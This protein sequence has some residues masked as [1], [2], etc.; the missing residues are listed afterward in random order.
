M[1]NCYNTSLDK[2]LFKN[3]RNIK[4]F[5]RNK[6]RTLKISKFIVFGQDKYGK[7]FFLYYDY[8]SK[9]LKN[10]PL[11]RN[12]KFF[13]YS[14]VTMKNENTMIVCGGIKY[15]LRDITNIAFEY[16]FIT[17]SC[18]RLPPM[19]SIRYTFPILYKDNFIYV[20]GGRTYGD[21]Y[22]SLLGKCERYDYRTGRWVEIASMTIKRCTCSVFVFNNDIWAIGGYTGRFKRSKKIE[23]YIED[24]DVWEVLDFKL[25][26]GFENGNVIPGNRPN[27]ILILG[28]KLNFG[29]SKNVWEYNLKN[30][31]VLN[32][33]KLQKKS[34]LTKYNIFGNDTIILSEE[35][36]NNKSSFYC[37]RYNKKSF[38]T[39]LDHLVINNKNLEK[40][41]QYNFSNPNLY[42]KSDNQE[43]IQQEIDYKNK[44]VIFGTDDEPFQL[45]IDCQSGIIKLLPIPTN[46]KLHNLQGC[47]RVNQNE[48]FFCGGIKVNLRKI[49]SLAF[50]YNLKTKKVEKLNKMFKIRYYFPCKKLANYIYAVG[51]RV[52]GNDLQAV[53]GDCERFDLKKKKWEHINGLNI[54]RAAS[55]LIVYMKKLFVFGGSIASAIPAKTNIIEVFNEK[56]ISWDV[57]GVKM[58]LKLSNI[59]LI[60]NN[61]KI[62]IFGGKNNRAN[63]CKYSLDLRLG[64]LS[65]CKNLDVLPFRTFGHFFIR[66]KNDFVI[67]GGIISQKKK[68]ICLLDGISLRNKL[69]FNHN[70]DYNFISTIDEESSETNSSKLDFY[71]FSNQLNKKVN[72]ASYS[73]NL[74]ERNS[75]ILNYE[76]EN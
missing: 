48:V 31:T 22:N 35:V 6:N 37:Q 17:H 44:N 68:Q 59:N 46:L 64:D 69:N 62:Y 1:G 65:E 9:Q 56:Y 39:K 7:S 32:K 55:N 70:S 23:R 71:Q 25:Y 76:E 11:P 66:V 34:V 4:I 57:L 5:D 16:D 75:F 67:F 40:F 60:S 73:V 36:V 47:T 21:D 58:P 3:K 43:R 45:N 20:I 14:G 42:L 8:I 54:N 30:K 74:M 13:N 41:K 63:N 27:E 38:T 12:S 33:R 53:I 29:F 18:K 28:G 26:Y 49:E 52:Y 24:L 19:K 51:G 61:N 15:S 72:M 2:K 50:I 10:C